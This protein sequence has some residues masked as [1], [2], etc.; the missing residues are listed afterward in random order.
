[1]YLRQA[2]GAL[3]DEDLCANCFTSCALDCF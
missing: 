2:I 3:N 1:V